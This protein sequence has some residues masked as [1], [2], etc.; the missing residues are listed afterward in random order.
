M[1]NTKAIANR[2]SPTERKRN[3]IM[4]RPPELPTSGVTN[5]LLPCGRLFNVHACG[6][7]GVAGALWVAR[8]ALQRSPAHRLRFDRRFR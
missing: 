1:K 2:K 7:F 5:G 3:R 6:L 4:G 8:F